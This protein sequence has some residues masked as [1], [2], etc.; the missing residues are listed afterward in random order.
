MDVREILSTYA[1]RWAIEVTHHDA[2][3]LLGLED[4]ANRLPLAV[5]RTAPMAMF[6]YSL[7][8]LW[9]AQHGHAQVRFPER[10]LVHS[11]KRTELCRHVNDATS[12]HVG[13]QIIASAT[14]KHCVEKNRRALHLPR[15][16][17]RIARNGP[18]T[19]TKECETRTKD[20]RGNKLPL[21][22]VR[23]KPSGAAKTGGLAPCRFLQ[24]GNLLPRTD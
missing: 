11:Q 2:K 21:L 12:R 8:V 22:A 16:P 14:D 7:T 15:N 3:Q 24:S 23:R 9:Y 5:Q 13:K 19:T 10:P 20:P 4:P 6:L 18:E 17:R 1:N